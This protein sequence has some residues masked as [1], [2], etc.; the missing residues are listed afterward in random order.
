MAIASGSRNECR[1]M[2]GLRVE[3]VRDR[4]Q[5]LVKWE[6]DK[7]RYAVRVGAT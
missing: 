6:R 1:G 2:V 5:V 4:V 3:G 7:L